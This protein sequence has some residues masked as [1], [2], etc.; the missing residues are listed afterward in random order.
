[1]SLQVQRPQALAELL[2][3]QRVRR[4]RRV[5]PHLRW[6]RQPLPSPERRLPEA[7]IKS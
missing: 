6:S 4:V 1:M 7:A 3:A 5:P 2:S